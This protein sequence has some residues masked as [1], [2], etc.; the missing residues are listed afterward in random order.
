MVK[1]KELK[2]IFKEIS[3]FCKNEC[4]S[5][6]NCAEDECVLFRIEKMLQKVGEK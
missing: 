4:G 1:N 2:P 6:D 5:S 3:N